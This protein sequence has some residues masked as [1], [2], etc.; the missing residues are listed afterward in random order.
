MKTSN[1]I[2]YV[3]GSSIKGVVRTA[4]LY[5]FLSNTNKKVIAE[6]IKSNIQ[7]FMKEKQLY[8]IRKEEFEKNNRGKQFFERFSTDKYFKTFGD[9]IEQLAFYCKAI[10]ENDKT[11]NDDDRFDILKLLSISDAILGKMKLPWQI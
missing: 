1:N 9:K 5:N 3:P 10:D 7:D 4:L 6:I 11:K 2:P 8:N